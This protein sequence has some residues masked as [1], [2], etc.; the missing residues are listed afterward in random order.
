MTYPLPNLFIQIRI[1][2]KIKQ[3]LGSG[4]VSN[5]RVSYVSSYLATIAMRC[6][7]VGIFS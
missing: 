5:F 6:A 7:Q 3:I 1:L 2:A 4:M